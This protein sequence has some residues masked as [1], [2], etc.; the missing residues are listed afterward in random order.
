MSACQ[1]NQ[2]WMTLCCPRTDGPTLL[3][4]LCALGKVTGPCPPALVVLCSSWQGFEG[5]WPLDSAP[6]NMS[7]V[8]KLSSLPLP[9]G[10]PNSAPITRHHRPGSIFLLTAVVTQ[11]A[12]FA[13]ALLSRAQ[14]CWLSRRAGPDSSPCP[15]RNIKILSCV[16]CKREKTSAALDSSKEAT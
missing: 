15:Q 4:H 13:A 10:Q 9:K 14:S 5:L 3:P 1:I 11:P 2:Q 16:C 8:Q 6:S 12:P 7:P